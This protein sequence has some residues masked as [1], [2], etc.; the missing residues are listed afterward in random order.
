MQLQTL[1][2]FLYFGL[3][4]TGEE[5]FLINRYS[6]FLSII[7]PFLSIF[8]YK[9]SYKLSSTEYTKLKQL[10]T[11]KLLATEKR[12]EEA[13][14]TPIKQSLPFIGII[15]LAIILFFGFNRFNLK[16]IVPLVPFLIILSVLFMVLHSYHLYTK[17][18]K[19]IESCIGEPI[20][21]KH[22]LYLSPNE[23]A[24]I[25]I[26]LFISLFVSF[27]LSIA[28]LITFLNGNIISY[29][30]FIFFLYVYLHIDILFTRTIYPSIKIKI[31]K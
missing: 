27:I 17:E 10:S 13:K 22:K 18:K 14:K 6:R 5:Y 24:G 19:S 28:C 15:V 25:I 7:I 2:G 21:Y 8:L 9:T 3:I 11:E 29:L 4:D 26:S 30:L 1:Y 20:R 12:L 16:F 31:R 23:T